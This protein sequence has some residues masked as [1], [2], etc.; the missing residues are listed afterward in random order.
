MKGMEFMKKMNDID[1]DLLEQ[2]EQTPAK[3][4]SSARH[5]VLTLGSLA[6]CLAL[7]IG[8]LSH[9]SSSPVGETPNTLKPSS[10]S[11][12][13]GDLS[14]NV[15]P[16]S[17][18]GKDADDTFC[19]A[20]TAFSLDL[21]QKTVSASGSKNMLISPYS[22]MQALAMTAN[23]A[24]GNTRTQMETAL[25][26]IA[27]E[28]LNPYLYTFRTQQPNDEFCKL[29]TANSI[30]IRDDADRISVFP[31][32]LQT[33]ADYYHANAYLVP[34]DD[35]TLEQINNW[36]N[37]STDYM[38]PK[39][40]DTIFPDEVMCLVNAVVFDAKWQSPFEDEP[41]P[42]DFTQADGS[43]KQAQMMYSE[44][45]AY[46]EAENATGFLKYYSGGRYAFAALLP[47][48]GLSAEEYVAGL[49]ADTLRDTLTN[50][51]TQYTVNIGLPKFSYDFDTE[52]SPTLQEMGMT[53]AFTFAANFSRIA[54]TPLAISR[55]I[56]K[57]H[58]DVDTEGTKAAA[59]T[60]VMMKD[61]CAP[62]ISET[63]TVILD[64]PFVYMILD[65][66]TDVP[67]FMGIL[68]EVTE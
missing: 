59:V 53:D 4:S 5:I 34:F 63:K 41:R 1:N 52:L 39:V 42:R 60:A 43:V 11:V 20:Q 31:E 50:V 51:D 35:S 46:L 55:V 36:C 22:V 12:K 62:V 66:E 58:I 40:L 37:V 30:W 8:V 16:Q 54:A 3:K 29:T 38:I 65:T 45:S 9:L 67:V 18:T 26:G 64:R 28:D 44:E 32:F 2:A 33:D 7:T 27:L 19:K 10:Q 13:A 56:H 23:G 25:G 6:A 17:V 14:A 24:D 57:T 61:E 47:E 68:E 48:E 21:L 49:T 15:Q